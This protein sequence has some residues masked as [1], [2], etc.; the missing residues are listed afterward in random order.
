LLHLFGPLVLHDFFN[1]SL[2]VYLNVFTFSVR[3]A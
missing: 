3:L 2:E 1:L